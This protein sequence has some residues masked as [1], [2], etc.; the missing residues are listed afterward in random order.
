[1]H[2]AVDMHVVGTQVLTWSGGVR[3]KGWRDEGVGMEG[4]SEWG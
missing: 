3:V 2:Q 1:M 4:R